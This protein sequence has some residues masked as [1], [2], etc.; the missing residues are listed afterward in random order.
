MANEAR[1]LN[2]VVF[3][4]WC[5]PLEVTTCKAAKKSGKLSTVGASHGRLSDEVSEL[6]W[7]LKKRSKMEIQPFSILKEKI[8][9]NM[10][11]TKDS[12][13]GYPKAKTYVYLYFIQQC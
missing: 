1:M 10:M 8:N 7:K 3:P 12:A 9:K 2:L 13:T 6:K 4:V 11:M 5:G